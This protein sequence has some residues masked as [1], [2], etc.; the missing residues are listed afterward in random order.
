MKRYISFIQASELTA[1]PMAIEDIFYSNKD[2]FL[3]ECSAIENE[4]KTISKLI[5]FSTNWLV[6]IFGSSSESFLV[7]AINFEDFELKKVRGDQYSGIYCYLDTTKLVIFLARLIE[8]EN[9]IGVYNTCLSLVHREVALLRGE[10]FSM[11]PGSYIFGWQFNDKELFEH[12]ENREDF[13]SLQAKHIQAKAELAI[14]AVA[15]ALFKLRIYLRNYTYNKHDRLQFS[16]DGLISMAMTTGPAIKGPVGGDHKVDIIITS[17]SVRKA[18]ELSNYAGPLGLDIV[19]MDSVYK[20]LSE[21]V[22]FCQRRPRM[23]FSKS[24]P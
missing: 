24:Q 1:K 23:L 12:S 16:M 15:S 11:L 5:N 2:Y 17:Q 22:V 18:V 3:A 19:I 21:E 20:L 10:I 4:W 9:Y 14:T 8:D 13:L 6:N 7:N